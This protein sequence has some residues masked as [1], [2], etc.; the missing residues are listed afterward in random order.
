[1]KP[2]QVL[3]YAAILLMIVGLVSQSA[4]QSPLV[5]P[6]AAET[7]KELADTSAVTTQSI[8]GMIVSG[9][10]MNIIFFGILGLFSL[11]A[12]TVV[13]E[14]VVNLRRDKLLPQ[15]F[16]S[17]VQRATEHHASPS[18]LQRIC[19]Q[20]DHAASRILQSG[21]LRSGRPLPEVEKAMEDSAA[22]EMAAMRGKSRPLSVVG[23]VAPL[24]GLLGTVVGMIMA[25]QISSQEGLG[26][27]ERLAEGIY[28]ALMTTAAGLTIAIP[29]LLFA[30]WFHS[31]AERYMCDIS[32]CLSRTMPTFAKLEGQA[33]TLTPLNKAPMPVTSHE[34]LSAR[35]R[36]LREGEVKAS[37][38]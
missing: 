15:S 10:T 31:K 5:Q 1:M 19:S 18:E 14:R 16:V 3:L 28:L 32:E 20:Q 7:E 23:N 38:G 24:V 35:E 26:K 6:T 25:F 37:K 36:F 12:V 27:A 33:V 34:E 13:L 22:R 21:L 29:C 17:D 9:G 4:A 11:W 8:G 2:I 30:S